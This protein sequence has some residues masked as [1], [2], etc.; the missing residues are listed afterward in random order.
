VIGLRKK[1]AARDLHHVEGE[2]HHDVTFRILDVGDFVTVAGAQLGIFE[3]HRTIDAQ[4]VARGIG[5][6]MGQCAQRECVLVDVVRITKQL[7]DEIT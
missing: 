6:V 3:G 7:L 1:R 4:R 2:L 5:D